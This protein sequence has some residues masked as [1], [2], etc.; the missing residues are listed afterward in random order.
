MRIYSKKLKSSKRKPAAFLI[1]EK[2]ITCCTLIMLI[3]RKHRF[4]DAKLLCKPLQFIRLQAFVRI[5]EKSFLLGEIYDTPTRISIVG[6]GL[7]F[8]LDNVTGRHCFP[9]FVMAPIPHRIP[10]GFTVLHR[11]SVHQELVIDD[12]EDSDFWYTHSYLISKILFCP[13]HRCDIYLVCVNISVPFG[14]GPYFAIRQHILDL[15]WL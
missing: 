1:H 2:W 8:F 13:I 12:K 7:E 14:I 11:N 15:T 4:C 3:P 5:E 10:V 6:S 9:K